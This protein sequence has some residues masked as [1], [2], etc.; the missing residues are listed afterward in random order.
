M[1]KR[2]F[3]QTLRLILPLVGGLAAGTVGAKVMAHRAFVHTALSTGSNVAE[4]GPSNVGSL[5]SRSRIP[6]ERERRIEELYSAFEDRV[7]KHKST[8]RDPEWSGAMEH[9]IDASVRG[10]LPL[11]GAPFKYEGTDCRTNTCLATV[12]WPSRE[13]AIAVLRTVSTIFASSN[14][15][16]DIALPP[17]SGRAGPLTA[18]VLLTCRGP[19]Q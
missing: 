2:R 4:G 16:S 12:A 10:I 11:P 9:T 14:C 1:R 13:T 3:G 15:S 6:E 8:P 17:A 5:E 7:N 19:V 18:F